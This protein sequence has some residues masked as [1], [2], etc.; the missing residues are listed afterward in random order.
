MPSASQTLRLRRLRQAHESHR[1]WLKLGLVSALLLSLA[2]VVLSLVGIGYYVDLTRNL[3]SVEIL[4]ALLNFP[5]GQLLQPTRLFD[6]SHEQVLLTLENPNAEGKHYL[7]VAKE[8]Q[9]GTE[10]VSKYLIDATIAELDPNFWHES[11]YS[12]SGLTQGTR[13][14]V[15][16]ILVYNLLLDN[17]APSLKRNIRERLLAA[18]IIYQYGRE[19]VLEWYLNSA[20]YGQTLYGADAAARVYFGKS[21]A[22]LSVAEAAMLTALAETPSVNPLTGSQILAHQQEAIIQKM[23]VSGLIN[24]D[25]A[26]GALKEEVHFREQ[27]ASH[28]LAPAFTE[29][30]LQQLSAVMPLERIYRGGFDIVTTLD[31]ALQEQ[32]DCAARAQVARLQGTQEP[33]LTYNGSPCEASRLLP[34]HQEELGTLNEKIGAEVVVIEPHNGQI[35]AMVGQDRSG[36]LPSEPVTHPAGTSLSPFMYLTAFTRGMSPATLLWDIP[37]DGG[38]NASTPVNLETTTSTMNTFHGP[39]SLR[40]AFVNDYPGAASEVLQQ[41]GAANVFLT[42]KLFGL[43]APDLS[44]Q[45]SSSLDN[46]VSQDVSLLES[47]HAYSVLANQGIVAGQPNIGDAAEVSHD[48]LSPS[49]TLKVESVDGQVLLDWSI[50]EMLPVVTRQIVY[51]TTN[52]LSDEKALRSSLGQPNSL[53]IGRPA[54]AKLSKTADGKGAWTVGYIPQLVVG[55]WMGDSPIDKSAISADMPA[56]LW[57]AIMQYAANEMP[58]QDFS[59]PSGI[60]LVQVCSPSG[61]LVSSLCPVIVQEVFLSGS[62]P[63]QIDNLY[64]KFAVDRETGLLATVFTPPELVEE[65]VF[66]AIPPQAKAWAEAAG[67]AIPPDT[68]DSIIVPQSVSPDVQINA[69]HMFDYVRGMVSIIGNAGGV[70][71]LYYR[72][73]VGQGLNPQK[74]LQIGEDVR[75]PVSNGTLGTWDTTGLEG[76]YIVQLLVVRQDARVDQAILQLT[77]DNTAPVVKII[78]PRDREQFGYRPG[79]TIL[80]NVSAIDNLVVE[81]VEF[82]VD[83]IL[84]STLQDTPYVIVW[85][86]LPGEHTLRVKAYDLAGNQTEA[87]ISFVVSR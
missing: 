82:Y 86:A 57:H 55:V 16:Q 11:G 54:A 63:T 74:W 45:V 64:Q 75:T 77:V 66:L 26:L 56:G 60:S 70:D 19:K 61:L 31:Y 9:V 21:A 1:P 42:E 84:E 80:M 30:V 20:Q 71:F 4:P 85:D 43:P 13:S 32:A 46:L 7:S 65:K 23:F 59:V 67:R 87:T 48:T 27:A 62:E 40:E 34:S 50:P 12:L 35:L 38:I 52:V 72:L 8:G 78:S 14:T 53:K 28:S 39:V 24:G 58:V 2:A 51:M 29:L 76:L 47:V 5:N 49:S 33:A 44:I 6:R 41:V 81:R 69:P 22:D 73:Q 83:D 18:Q 15:A 25:E 36:M 37:N 3:P 17:E 79:M 68:Y 10:Q